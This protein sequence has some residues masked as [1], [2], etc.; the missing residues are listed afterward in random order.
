MEGVG[1][2]R[3]GELLF[4]V[5]NRVVAKTADQAAEKRGNSG[6]DAALM[7]AWQAETKSRGLSCSAWLTSM[8]RRYSAQVWPRT[9]KRVS[10][11]KR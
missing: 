10:A 11:G 3:G 5:T 6:R 1:L 2:P 7:R 9:S 4:H 8:P